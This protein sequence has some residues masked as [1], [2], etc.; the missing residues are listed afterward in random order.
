MNIFITLIL[1]NLLYCKVQAILVSNF[2]IEREKRGILQQNVNIWKSFPINFEMRGDVYKHYGEILMAMKEIERY[3]CITFK[4]VYGLEGE[5]LLFR[6]S[7]SGFSYTDLKKTSDDKP[8]SIYL[9][10]DSLRSMG[11]NYFRLIFRSLG[12]DYEFNR[13]DRD[14][15]IKINKNNLY[16]RNLDVEKKSLLKYN[17][18]FDYGSIMQFTNKEVSKN[19]KSKVFRAT[20]SLFQRTIENVFLPTFNNYKLLNLY[21]CNSRCQNRLE[22]PCQNSGYQDYDNCGGCK[23][24]LFYAGQ[25]CEET[26]LH[27]KHGC[28]KGIYKAKSSYQ[29]ITINKNFLCFIQINSKKGTK[30]KIKI[31]SGVIG[32]SRYCYRNNLQIFYQK[33]KSVTGAT[34]CG[35]V[36]C[37]TI[38]SKDN[39]VFMKWVDSKRKNSFKIKY[40]YIEN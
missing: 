5:G 11:R 17:T 19:S 15:F 30:I 29:T 36:K 21:H 7:K 6:K 31:S 23:C 2:S 38:K 37:A 39:I 18:T 27:K 22:K 8:H 40:K 33:D 16:Y 35:H 14:S 10:S 20:D 3:T 1:F 24:P 34:F 32:K 4:L 28:G 12:I 9:A 13:D 26:Y 25:F